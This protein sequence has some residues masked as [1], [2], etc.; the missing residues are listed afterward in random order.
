MAQ[1][2]SGLHNSHNRR[3]LLL[4][5]GALLFVCY[6]AVGVAVV[7]AH[8]GQL[9]L[10]AGLTVVCVMG[11]V[12]LVW[13]WLE[14]R[15]ERAILEELREDEA[16][17]R[18]LT[19]QAPADVWT[20]DADLRLTSILGALIPQLENAEA[21]RPGRTLYE[22]LGTSDPSHPVIAA[23][24]QAL[25]GESAT[26]ERADG[27]HMLEGRVEPLRDDRGG[28]IGCV[29]IAMDVSTWRWAE[30]QV[31][32]FAA[33]VQSSE[34]AIISTDVDGII[35]TWNPAAERLYGYTVAEAVGKPITIVAPPGGES[36]IERNIGALRQGSAL[37]PSETRR[38]RQDGQIIDVSVTISPIRDGSGQVL[39]MSGIVRDVTDRR[40][41]EEA[42]RSSEERFRSVLDRMHLIGVGLDTKG[43]ITYCNAYFAEL[44]SWPREELIGSDYLARFLPPE[45]PVRA[46]F[47]QAM[48]GGEIPPHYVNDILVRDGHCRT[49]Q[50]NNTLLRD[51]EGGVSGVVSIGEDVTEHHKA[52][53]ELRTSQAELRALAKHLATVREKEDT[54][55]AREIHDQLGQ[56]LTALR[57]DLS[58]LSKKG[59]GDEAVRQKLRDMV[60]LADET[61]EAARQ[62]AGELRPPILDDL[63]LVPALKWYLPHIADR[64]EFTARLDVTPKDLAVERELG[65]T[66]YRIV[67][68][69]L[70]NVARHAEAKHVVVALS[71]RGDNL[72][73]EVRDDGRGIPLAAAQSRRSL[74]IVGMRER[75]RER[76]G[77]LAVS[78]GRGQGTTVSV[79]M[80]LERR[81][82]PRSSP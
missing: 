55:V 48:A 27:G 24:L 40:R 26:Y 44:T 60:V 30:S 19:Q 28:M 76:G 31:R 43:I 9:G 22:L 11:L 73:V 3:R 15:H 35:E 79:A 36:E 80:P 33:L 50:W 20:T 46:M 12:L 23:H 18:L 21:R 70:T 49:I 14:M 62:I 72:T 25:R 71:Q 4:V 5:S 59:R 65:V 63:G 45:H 42:L 66:V 1:V 77:T 69:A 58:W 6:C 53:E 68:E 38:R 74:G 47:A 13:G 34:D 16:R 67:Q 32:R 51:A 54:R 81:R 2:T 64:A 82:A 56:A 37:G 41:A 39:G 17:L 8:S 52:V 29:G 57:L 61:I 78:G 10:S 7:F 75:A